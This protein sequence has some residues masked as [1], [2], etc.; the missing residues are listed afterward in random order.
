[1]VVRVK[2]CEPLFTY[3]TKASAPKRLA[4]TSKSPI[5]V[6]IGYF[7]IANARSTGVDVDGSGKAHREPSLGYQ[8]MRL[9]L[10]DD[11]TRSVSPSRSTSI[12]G[13]ESALLSVN[14]SW[15]ANAMVFP[16]RFSYQVILLSPND[17]ERC[18]ADHRC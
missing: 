13:Y 12:P 15:T 1:M 8:V 10:M 2:L 9:S 11:V 7:Y 4:N 14:K 17:T 18:P 3:H 6:D 5:T 16:P